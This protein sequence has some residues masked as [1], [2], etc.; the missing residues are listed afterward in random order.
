MTDLTL[1]ATTPEIW[2]KLQR[3]KVQT[4]TEMDKLIRIFTEWKDV[5]LHIK[6]P[7]TIQLSD[8]QTIQQKVYVIGYKTD[9]KDLYVEYQITGKGPK[10][11]QKIT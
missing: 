9:G 11:T 3:R 7:F 6:R 10:L 1:H 5:E 4:E 8:G 2:Y